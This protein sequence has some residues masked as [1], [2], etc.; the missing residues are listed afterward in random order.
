MASRVSPNLKAKI[1][2]DTSGFTKGMAD[3]KKELRAFDKFGSSAL[4]DIASAFGVNAQQV[5]KLSLAFA[6]L[7]KKIALMGDE[8][9]K[10]MKSLAASTGGL[11]T[12][13]GALGI[14]T[15]VA[16][17]KLLNAEAEAFK[18]TVQGANIALQTQAYLNT[19]KQAM[20]DANEEIGKG[21]AEAQASWQKWTG[22]FTG[23]LATQVGGGMG[24]ATGM[25]AMGD[26]YRQQASMVEE[27]TKAY[28]EAIAK[29]EKA[30]SITG[31]I[32][33]LQL[34][35]N[36]A[37]RQWA[38]LEKQ[39]SELRLTVYDQ[40]A[41]ASER[42]EAL[43]QMQSLIQQ[44]YTEQYE[45]QKRISELTDEMNGLTSN[46]LEDTQKANQLYVQSVGTLT[47]MNN[48]LKALER[49][50]TS[51]S[52]AAQSEA[53][54]R[55]ETAEAIAK[56]VS[57]MQEYATAQIEMFV[58]DE[59]VAAIQNKLGEALA[60]APVQVP[61]GLD[62]APAEQAVLDLNDVIQQ[63]MV[64]G[65]E[66]IADA[67]GTL[68]G[69]LMTGEGG[70][71]DFGHDLLEMVGTFAQKFGKVL[72]AFGVATEAFKASAKSFNGIAA[73]IAGGALI[74]AGAAV[75]AVASSMASSM[76]GA[77]SA[78]SYVASSAM[79]GGGDYDSRML[80]VEVT[81]TLTANGSQLVAVL[82]NEN[83]RK[84][85]AS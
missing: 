37:T 62:I 60:V 35:Q 82:N 19:Y 69:N 63:T 17:F 80:K 73:I 46:S 36:N 14:G 52:K 22:T 85:Y 39:I 47:Q 1:G 18:N 48:E 4:S 50:S 83:N 15:A 32:Y 81:G 10:T 55:K 24:T 26:I 76:G 27:T 20:H 6:G 8:G 41:S 21:V 31:E 49:V 25:V 64:E 34:R 45:I 28:N 61:V 71:A 54:A 56:G 30:E 67:I 59:S 70:V 7:T 78:G 57:R 3:V 9:G 77:S 40:E 42:R 23:R 79:S 33:Q 53:A 44:K 12:A 84:Y 74:A 66:G 72:V 38:D 65:I 5:E 13:I 11:A 43:V 68:L 58:S 51:I 75:K 29:A 2:A 16:A